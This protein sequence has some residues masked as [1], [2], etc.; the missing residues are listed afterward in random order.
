MCIVYVLKVQ[1][2]GN[3]KQFLRNISQ[4]SGVYGHF[5]RYLSVSNSRNKIIL[6]NPTLPYIVKM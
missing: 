4:C 3:C 2:T 6:K 5:E 1:I